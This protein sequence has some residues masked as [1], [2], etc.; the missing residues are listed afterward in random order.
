VHRRADLLNLGGTLATEAGTLREARAA[1]SLNVAS[2]VT[3]YDVV[4]E[5]D[6]A[7]HV[8]FRATDSG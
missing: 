2:V 5:D 6:G 3:I 1:A 4:E 8:I 7:G